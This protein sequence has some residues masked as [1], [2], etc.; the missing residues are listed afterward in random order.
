MNLL[1][2]KIQESSTIDYPGEFVSVIFFCQCI[3]RCPFCQN[4]SL[5]LAE[6]CVNRSIK[7]I[8]TQLEG[9]RKYITGICITGGEPTIQFAGLVELLKNIQQMGLLSKLDTNGFYSDRIKRLIDSKLLN[10][11]ALDIKAPLVPNQYGNIIGKP[12]LGEEAVR[13]IILTLKTLQKSAIPF[14]TRTTI[15]PNCNDSEED[16]VQ[17]VKKLREFNISKYILQQFRTLGGTLE[18]NF[19]ELPITPYN[20]L[21]RLAK[22]ARKYIP[23]VRIRTIEAG[24][25]KI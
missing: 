17:I 9:Y 16:I 3:F 10:Y 20:N 15:I 2:G 18:K 1:I 12:D 25:E 19:S 6:D 5:V 21:V 14:E 4:W 23:D 8:I 24:E 11:I 22:I 13:K 7:D